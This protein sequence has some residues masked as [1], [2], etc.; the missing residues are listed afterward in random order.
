MEEVR[1][2]ILRYYQGIVEVPCEIKCDYNHKRG[3]KRRRA[4]ITIFL[5]Q[6]TIYGKPCE[7]VKGLDNFEFDLVLNRRTKKAKQSLAR[8]RARDVG[9]DLISKLRTE[10]VISFS[11]KK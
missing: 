1:N 4:Y 2:R 6:T 10:G 8:Q 9:K 3:N 5:S 11:R 7:K